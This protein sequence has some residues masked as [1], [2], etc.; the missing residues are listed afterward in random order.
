MLLCPSS[1]LSGVLR[2]SIGLDIA[3]YRSPSPP[4][5]HIC[6]QGNSLSLLIP[7]NPKQQPIEWQRT[8]PGIKKTPPRPPIAHPSLTLH[9]LTTPKTHQNVPTNQ[10]QT[11]A[12]PRPPHQ[13]RRPQPPTPQ[14]P[15][16][17]PKQP[18]ATRKPQNNHIRH[19]QRAAQPPPLTTHQARQPRR[20]RS[21]PQSLAARAPQRTPPPRR[22]RR[23]LPAPQPVAPAQGRRARVR[24]ACAGGDACGPEA[25]ETR[26]AG[27][28]WRPVV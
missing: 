16:R 20:A 8:E 17:H 2:S 10:L 18:T 9:L 21:S 5:S 11:S 14:P 13:T 22:R 7:R 24:A 28:P 23:P 3:G 19:R 15:H 25:G 6:L 1:Q 26:S 12:K 4:H 27:Y